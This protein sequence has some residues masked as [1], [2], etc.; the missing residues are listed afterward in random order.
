MLHSPNMSSRE[1]LF[2]CRQ[3]NPTCS[4]NELGPLSDRICSGP[5]QDEQVRG[6]GSV[7]R[8]EAIRILGLNFKACSA[9]S[10]PSAPGPPTDERRTAQQREFSTSSV[11]RS[12]HRELAAALQRRPTTCLDPLPGSRPGGV[13]AGSRPWPAA[14]PKPAPPAMLPLVPGPALNTNRTTRGGGHSAAAG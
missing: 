5:K 11:R 9:G 4:G 6:G 2:R 13:R 8:L 12:H 14:Q 1:I 3:Q 7:R 10:Q